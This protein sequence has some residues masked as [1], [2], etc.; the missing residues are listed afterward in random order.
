MQ[1]SVHRLTKDRFMK[2]TYWR[3]LRL[4][5]IITIYTCGKAIVANTEQQCY[6]STHLFVGGYRNN[7]HVFST[8][9]EYSYLS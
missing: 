1:V 6:F 4:S 7:S 5:Y 3:V 9:R 8:T 2:Q